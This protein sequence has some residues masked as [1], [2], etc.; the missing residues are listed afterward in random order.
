MEIRKA[1]QASDLRMTKQTLHIKRSD[2][3]RTRKRLP[4]NDQRIEKLILK[5]LGPEQKRYWMQLSPAKK[6][7][8]INQVKTY[9]NQKSKPNKKNEFKKKQAGEKSLPVSISKYNRT[10]QKQSGRSNSKSSVVTTG[11]KNTAGTIKHV[12]AKADTSRKSGNV[13]CDI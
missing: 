5:Q 4:A 11:V 6:Q 3:Q 2:L 9:S 13:K 7:E 10:S 12:V 8:Y 1:K